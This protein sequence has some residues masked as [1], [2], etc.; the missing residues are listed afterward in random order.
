MQCKDRILQNY[1]YLVGGVLSLY[2]FLL[3]FITFKRL[4]YTIIR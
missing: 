4:V 3:I 1:Q 2:R